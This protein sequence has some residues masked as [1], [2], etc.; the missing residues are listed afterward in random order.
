M[1]INQSEWGKGEFS[2]ESLSLDA[3]SVAKGT[4]SRL[5]VATGCTCG[6]KWGSVIHWR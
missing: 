1:E 2:E 6:V 5:P 3:A 4:A